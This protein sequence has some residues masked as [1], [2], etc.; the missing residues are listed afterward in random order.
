MY[1]INENTMY[2]AG[3]VTIFLYLASVTFFFFALCIPAFTLT[4]LILTGV[5]FVASSVILG[6]MVKERIGT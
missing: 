4:G 6:I 1:L 5:F 3:N 2:S